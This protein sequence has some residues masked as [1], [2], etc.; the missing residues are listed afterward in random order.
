MRGLFSNL[1]QLF[2]QIF[3][4][5]KNWVSQAVWPQDWNWT[6]GNEEKIWKSWNKS[7]VRLDQFVEFINIDNGNIP[8]PISSAY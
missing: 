2:Q 6:E 4:D 1:N 3:A 5:Y 8:E 7:F